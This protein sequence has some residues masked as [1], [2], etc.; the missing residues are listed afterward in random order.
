MG[1]G[2][3]SAGGARLWTMVPDA[4]LPAAVYRPL[5]VALRGRDQ[6]RVPHL[7]DARDAWEGGVRRS[8]LSGRA[9][10]DGD[11][12]RPDLFDDPDPDRR[13]RPPVL[14]GARVGPPS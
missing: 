1:R 8:G 11:Q 3:C 5:L 7:A 9:E 13:V 10:N 14:G 6:P 12:Y 4:G 2:E